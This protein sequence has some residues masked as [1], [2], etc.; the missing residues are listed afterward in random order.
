MNIVEELERLQELYRNGTLTEQD[1]RQAKAAVLA[2]AAEGQSTENTQAVHQQLEELQKQNAILKIDRDWLEERTQHVWQDDFGNAREPKE[3]H[4][5]FAL[6]FGIIFGTCAFVVGICAEGWTAKGV[7]VGGVLALVFIAIFAG[8]SAWY[9]SKYDRYKKAY[10]A[11]QE[12]RAAALKE[13]PT[14]RP[15]G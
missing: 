2:K 12:R 9:Y 11:Y 8:C 6:V 13:T 1:F 7:G 4:W 3:W 15:I 14:D 5:I 10:A